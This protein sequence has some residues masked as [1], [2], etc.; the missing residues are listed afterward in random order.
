M[1]KKRGYCDKNKIY[2]NLY[3]S[4][5]NIKFLVLLLREPQN[6]INE[7]CC[8]VN[9]QLKTDRISF[10]TCSLNNNT[11]YPVKFKISTFFGN[12][13]SSLRVIP[14][15]IQIRHARL[16]KIRSYLR[17]IPIEHACLFW[18]LTSIFYGEICIHNTVIAIT[19]PKNGIF[20]TQA[21]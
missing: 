13:F 15:H 6:Y 1:T 11:K 19:I 21:I 10:S 14:W 9:H 4:Y 12:I 18:F 17:Q 5:L 8:W 3:H 7:G 2:D 16:Y 20:I